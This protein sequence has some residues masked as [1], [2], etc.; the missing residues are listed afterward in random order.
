VKS[1]STKECRRYDTMLSDAAV[2]T[3]PNERKTTAIEDVIVV[4]VPVSDQDRA[5]AFYV[6][7]LGFELIR[8]DDSI[9][10]FRWIQVAPPGGTT[11]LTLV[12]WFESMPAGSLRGLVLRS[13]DIQADYDTLVARGMRFDGPPVP[14]PYAKA[15]TVFYD[16][17]GNSIV[18]QQR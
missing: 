10:G 16:P 14:Q 4:S 2:T 8:E 3:G 13:S 18:L 11:S 5:R 9:P 1:S 17:D 7:T 15:E 12:T 6:E